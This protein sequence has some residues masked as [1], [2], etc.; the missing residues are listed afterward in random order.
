MSKIITIAHQ[1]GG[2]GKSTISSN[3][4]VEYSKKYD[5]A[6]LDLDVQHSLTAFAKKRASKHNLKLNLLAQPTT[7][8]ELMRTIDNTKNE[9]LIIDTG[10]FDV[11]IQR[12]AMYAADIIITPVSDSPMELHGLSVFANTIK[13]LKKEKSDIKSYVIFNRVHQFA[14]KSLVELAKDINELEQ[15]QVLD[16]VLRDKKIYKDAYFDAM[17]V[18]EYDNQNEASKNITS[19]LNEI[20][21]IILL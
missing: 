5:T 1:K 4:A 2:V 8:K 21:S 11:D 20:N 18:C 6:I 13:Q 7:A 15:Y 19:L 10:G 16:T 9:V 12:I 14:N 3:I 17:S